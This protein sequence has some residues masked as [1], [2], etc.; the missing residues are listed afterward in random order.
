MCTDCN[1]ITIPTGATGATGAT[2]PQ[3]PAGTNG[4]NGTNG[5]NGLRVL[6]NFIG[7][8]GNTVT[9]GTQTLK[10]YTIAA[11]E[12]LTAGDEIEIDLICAIN[13]VGTGT[14][15]MQL[16]S[17]T[18]AI[19]V[20]TGTSI[21]INTK[22]T[23]I[24]VSNIYRTIQYIVDNGITS[25]SRMYVSSE[26]FNTTISNNFSVKSTLS[27]NGIDQIIVNKF[28]IYKNKI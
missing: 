10:F 11:N 24:D 27:A 6:S 14:I 17:N 16:G 25:S 3:G 18:S 21:R 9:L 7:A 13:L 22:I 8:A 5:V 26:L 4:T 28:S 1:E 20:T 23:M 2:G 12:L 19:S 15:S